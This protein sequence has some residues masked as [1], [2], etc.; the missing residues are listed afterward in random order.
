[1]SEWTLLAMFVGILMFFLF[2][3][4]PVAYGIGLT[5]VVLMIFGVGRSLNAEIFV[6]RMFFGLNNFTLLAIPFFL[7]AG[8]I[9]NVGGMTTRIFDFS[10]ALVGSMKGGLGHVNVVASMIFA[11]MSGLATADAAGLGAIEYKAMKDGGY[12][13]GCC[14][15]LAAASS[16]IGA[17]FPPSVP[18]VMF[19]I[20][21][22][23]SVG[24]LL[25]GGIVPGLL[26][27]AV[28][29]AMVFVQSHLGHLPQGIHF[30]WPELWKTFKRGILALGTPIIL[31]SGIML[32]IFTPTEAAAVT[33][34]YALLLAIF[35]YREVN[36]K[37]LW[38]VI[39][40][41][42]I[43]STV[44]IALI[45][46]ASIY[47]FL[48][49]QSQVPQIFASKVLTLTENPYMI[50]LLVNL[51]LL[52]VGMF[53][54]TMAIL[55]ILT[56]ILLPLVR[57]VGVDPIHFGIIMN[58]NLQIGLMTPPFGMLLFVLNKATGVPLGKVI[59]GV[60]LYYVP[61]IICLILITYF[62][63][64]T[65]WLPNLVFGG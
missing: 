54:E 49:V 19:A 60:L 13:E 17:I 21:A 5:A 30:S 33:V 41:T 39:K 55:G 11:G 7:F 63:I 32:G 56:P 50:L 23:L 16:T 3:G 59:R 8:R 47:G 53:M 35:I 9:M 46:M 64:F 37:D 6:S 1:M 48:I 15:G 65:L 58:F 29:M 43:D 20:I 61:L 28:L 42:A 40:G 45:G 36:I 27:G 62:P 4:Y 18:I 24:Q 44:I 22:H 14:V 25:I 31:V 51:L 52:T 38:E 12:P 57:E 34:I 26:I 2:T 10:K